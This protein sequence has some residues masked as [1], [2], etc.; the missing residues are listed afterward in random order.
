MDF[1]KIKKNSFR[2]KGLLCAA[3]YAQHNK[4]YYW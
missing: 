4:C 3:A 1:N 2:R